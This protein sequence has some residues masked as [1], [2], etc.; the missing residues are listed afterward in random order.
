MG[1]VRLEIE[2]TVAVVTIDRPER[3][4]A[5]DNDMHAQLQATWLEVK[6][7]TDVRAIVMTGVGKGFCVG[8]DLQQVTTNGGF[9]ES[10]SNR[11]A[12]TFRMT[13]LSN[14]IW[15]PTIVAVNGVCA[16]GGLHFVTD[17][18]YVLA[19]TQARFLDPH[20]AVG[21]VSALEPITLLHRIGLGAALRLSVLGR[22]GEF[23]AVDA[24]RVGLA[25]ELVDP[26]RLLER[27]L[28]LAHGASQASPAAVERSKR[29]I[30]AAL[31]VPLGEALQ[32][33]WESIVAHR[34]HPD[35]LEGPRAFAEKRAP[36][37]AAD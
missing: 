30:W 34:A 29:A 32:L 24:F 4:G 27:A 22:A 37:W 1:K 20:C 35:A 31:E 21:Q 33:G 15:V 19:S 28:E 26:D 16:G 3:L 14:D 2:D 36:Q 13:P 23:S 18:D 5:L 11:I 8:M 17:A 6:A 10:T 25:D 7:R 12:D 9:R